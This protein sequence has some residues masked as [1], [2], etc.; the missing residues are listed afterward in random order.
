MYFVCFFRMY[1][2][3]YILFT[4]SRQVR[5]V[6]PPMGTFG[7]NQALGHAQGHI[8][9]RM[10][11][12]FYIHH[13]PTHI[14]PQQA[15]EIHEVGTR[16]PPIGYFWAQLGIGATHVWAHLLHVGNRHGK[17]CRN[18]QFRNRKIRPRNN[19]ICICILGNPYH[20]WGT[21]EP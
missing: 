8:F 18:E 20:V 12:H 15:G 17:R 16:L 1:A 7:P 21:F 14:L 10:Y 19:N 11:A 4:T 2:Y 3:F 6:F 9:F 5:L 13:S